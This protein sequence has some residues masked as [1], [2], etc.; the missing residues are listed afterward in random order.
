MRPCERRRRHPH[1][2]PHRR[3]PGRARPRGPRRRR[4]GSSRNGAPAVTAANFW[5]NSPN[6]RCSARRRT[7]PKAAASQKAVAPP[8]PRTTSIAV[9]KREELCQSRADL[10]H[11]GLNGLLPVRGAHH[12]APSLVRRASAS[13][14]T[15]EG[16]QP[17]RPSA[18]LSS[19]GNDQLPCLLSGDSASCR[20]SSLCFLAPSGSRGLDD[21]E[22]PRRAAKDSRRFPVV[23]STSAPVATRE[24]SV[25]ND[26]AGRLKSPPRGSRSLAASTTPEHLPARDRRP[27]ARGQARIG[28]PGRGLGSKQAVLGGRTE[29]ERAPPQTGRRRVHAVSQ[30]RGDRRGLV[31]VLGGDPHAEPSL[32]ERRAP[33]R[34]AVDRSGARRPPWRR[35]RRARSG[36][37]ARSRPP[38]GR[39]SPTSCPRG[40]SPRSTPRSLL[41][42]RAARAMEARR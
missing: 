32:R 33:L 6:A 9:G 19:C 37:R 42:R 31:T 28:Y 22:V 40:T 17:K 7:R 15:F 34:E 16:P 5:E 20:A 21:R 3:R 26:L 38:R 12:R 23:D 14:R 29:R 2:R 39:R 1:P 11:Q 27:P 13:G 18:G 35:A 30:K 8:L 25:A 41:P 10:A 24:A 4:H 36:A